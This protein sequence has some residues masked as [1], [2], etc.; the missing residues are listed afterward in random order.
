MKKKSISDMEKN[1]ERTDPNSPIQILE[2]GEIQAD[3]RQEG[4]PTLR[5][6]KDAMWWANDELKHVQEDGKN[7]KTCDLPIPLAKLQKCLYGLTDEALDQDEKDRADMLEAL[8]A[9]IGVNEGWFVHN[10]RSGGKTT[11]M[12]AVRLATKAIAKAEG[13]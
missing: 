8:K 6:M 11:Y 13:K 4:P 7:Y 3:K 10:P 1:G 12:N 9:F 5:E 2:S